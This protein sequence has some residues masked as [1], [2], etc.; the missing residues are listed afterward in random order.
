MPEQQL[1]EIACALG[2]GARIVIMDEPTASLTRREQERLFSLVRALRDQSV[3]IIYISHRLE[4]IFA[5]ADRVTVLRDGA[6]I[7]T[8]AVTSMSE[9]RLIELMVGREVAHLYPPTEFSEGATRMDVRALTCKAS[10]LKQ[11]SF[12]V[13]AGEILGLSGLVGAA[14][15]NWLAHSSE[16]RRP[17][18]ARF[19]STGSLSPSAIPGWP[20]RLV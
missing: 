5:L 3:G 13:R 2:A 14:G 19:G 12:T 16:S 8:H 18:R 6:S 11:V 10:G 17:T 15:R 7:G 20:W 1:V 9:S 4:E